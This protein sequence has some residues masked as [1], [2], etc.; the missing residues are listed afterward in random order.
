MVQKTASLSN[1]RRKNLHA[2]FEY[3]RKFRGLRYNPVAVI[4]KISQDRKPQPVPT[5][6]E[7]AKLKA[8]CKTWQDRALIDVIANSGARRSE[9]FRLTLADVD[10]QARE[11]RFGNRKNKRRELKYR[12]VPMNDALYGA[13]LKLSRQ[14]LPQ[15]EYLFQNRDSRHPNYGGRYTARRRFMAGLCKTAKIK[16]MGFHSLRRYF[17]SKLVQN[18]ENLETVRELMGHSAVSTTDRYVY[19][20]RSDAKA[21]V[22]RIQE[23]VAHEVAHAASEK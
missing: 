22:N 10:F 12:T 20:L 17:A 4:D 3:C 13:L 7:L 1:E 8:S 14:R 6:I 2:F 18:R 23:K 9:V 15:S 11:V 16:H 19:R 21:A 5:D